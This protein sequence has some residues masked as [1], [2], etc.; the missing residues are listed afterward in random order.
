MDYLFLYYTGSSRSWPGLD[1]LYS[2]HIPVSRTE[3]ENV[4]VA[5][6]TSLE[7]TYKQNCTE[8]TKR[9]RDLS[10]FGRHHKPSHVT[11]KETR[12]YNRW[13]SK[14]LPLLP[15]RVP[16][17]WLW[18][19]AFSCLSTTQNEHLHS[20][21]KWLQLSIMHTDYNCLAREYTCT[22]I[23]RLQN[24]IMY[25]SQIMYYYL[26]VEVW[27]FCRQNSEHT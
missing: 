14:H 21:L 12:W 9:W 4:C 19:I 16:M 11:S 13:R 5:L 15:Y 24:L 8:A 2:L 17:Q 1:Q 10:T 3:E 20:C 22:R 26:A 7:E 25:Y 6:S 18:S 27:I 23:D